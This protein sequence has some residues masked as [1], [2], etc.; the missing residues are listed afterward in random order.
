MASVLI[1]DDS[2]T[3]RK[4]LRNLF[5]EEGYEIAGE[6]GDGEVAIRMYKELKPDIVSMDITMPIMNGIDSLKR[7][8]EIDPDAKVVMVT[9]AGQQSKMTEAVKYGAKDFVT[10]PFE[11]ETVA[12]VFNK[13]M[14]EDKNV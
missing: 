8:M 10:K 9:S 5:I 12:Y 14:K 4:I 1:V 7:I 13:I 6:A 11:N 2:R 3:S